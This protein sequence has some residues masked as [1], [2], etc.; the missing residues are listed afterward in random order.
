[1]NKIT[2]SLLFGV[3]VLGSWWLYKQTRVRD[4]FVEVKVGEAKLHVIVRDTM[5]GRS[6]GLSGVE[7][8][9]S[10]EGMLFVFP[11]VAK[12]SFWMKEMKFDLDFIW[13]RNNKVV[14]ITEGVKAEG[15]E[16]T[17]VKPKVPVNKV[18]EVNS[19]FVEKNVIKVG[20][21]VN[22]Y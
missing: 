10:D 2:F 16:T 4:G 13:I 14:D 20:D 15:G 7:K 8:L 3:I 12:Y 6:K 22:V 11:V 18:L 9:K 1:M 19:C 17:M 5:E 21:R